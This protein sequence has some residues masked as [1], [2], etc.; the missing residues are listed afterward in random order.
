MKKIVVLFAILIF[1]IAA[2]QQTAE[3]APVAQVQEATSTGEPTPEAT[4]TMAPTNSPTPQATA[5]ETATAVPTAAPTAEPT[6]E[7]TPSPVELVLSI[8]GDHN[9]LNDPSGM[10]LD[11]QGN[12][13]VADTLNHR[14][15]KFDNDG[16]FLVTWGS[17]G[18]GDGQFNFIWGDPNHNLALG[19]VAIDG[20]G[21]V[22]VADGGNARI[23]K[24]D[25]EGNFLTKWGSQGSGDGQFIRP[26]DLTVDQDGN[27]YV[28]DDRSS[29]P[30]RI[31][32]FD[33]NGNF[34]ARFGEGLFADP[35][36]ITID[37]QGNLYATDWA[38]GTI[39][40]LDNNGGLL[41]TWGSYGSADGE[42]FGPLGIEL[43][44][45]GNIYVVD[46][47]N[48]R[49][50]KLDSNGNFLFE[51]GRFREPYGIRIDDDGSI[52]VSDYLN[53][54]IQKFR[55]LPIPNGSTAEL[56]A[57]EVP[58]TPTDEPLPEV[59]VE[60]LTGLWTQSEGVGEGNNWLLFNADGSY[61]AR[62]GPSFETGVPVLEG[63][64]RVESGVI[65]LLDVDECP[66]GGEQYDVAFITPERIRFDLKML[67]APP[68]LLPE[69]PVWMRFEAAS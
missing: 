1:V 48:G 26:M 38:R 57:T 20:Q 37:G 62:H 60:S 45:Q 24:F 2:C 44:D 23:Q 32:K 10:D 4:A 8:T 43:D 33:S 68:G 35:G 54:R 12:L 59:S 31:Q 46:S 58:S 51:W 14:I 64:Y 53:D 22:Y 3:P 47:R 40:K 34:L 66:E 52:Y 28:I 30:G 11:A 42:F 18:S 9:S 15:Q 21:N 41:A 7:P 56:R 25:S 6:I 16:Q 65:T 61:E 69:T 19:D 27:V 39:L 55:L 17:E 13:Y 67:C 49:V 63:T 5:T 50:Q 36:G 29:P